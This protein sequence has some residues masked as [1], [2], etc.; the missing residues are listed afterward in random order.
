MGETDIVEIIR[1]A[2][3]GGQTALSE[4]EA[5]QF[6]A[7]LGIPVCRGVMAADVAAAVT[8][9]IKLG[10][11]VVLKAIGKDLFHKTEVRGI[12]LNLNGE[13][14]VRQEG[15]R[16]LGI[17]ESEALLV[18]EM[19]KGDRELVCGL[20]RDAQFGPCVMFGL[21]G[22]LTEVLQDVVFRVAP[23]TLWDAR[24][25][26]KEIQHGKILE[27]FRG[28]VAVDLDVLSR[29]LVT[30]GEIG[31][32]YQEVQSVDIN[33]LKIQPDGQPVA[34]DALVT[35]GAGKPTVLG[36]LKKTFRRNDLARFFEPESVAVIGASAMSGKA[37][38]VVVKNILAN[39]YAGKLY[40]VNP[41]GGE[42]LGMSVHSSIANLPDGVEQAIIMTPAKDTVQV[43]R[44][45]AVR[46]IKYVVLAAGG[47]SEVDK[48]GEE[49]QEELV[50]TITETGVRAIGPNTSGHI[51]T[52]HHYTSGFFPLDRI[53]QGNI[54]YVTQ[55]GNFAT[56]T[57]RY[58]TTGEYFGVARVI[59]LG[60]KIDIDESEV[61][62]YYAE[63]KET[64]AIFMYLE[65]IRRPRR[66][67][68][69]ADEVTRLKPVFL[70]KGGNTREG[71]RAAVTHT[72]ALA[73]DERIM[74]GALIQAGVTRLYDYSHLFLVAKALAV[75]PLPRGSGVSFLAPSGA[76]LVVLTDMCYQRWGLEVPDLEEGTRRRL[77]EISPPYIR[78]RNP[79]DIWPSVLVHDIEYSYRE[80]IEVLMRDIN[81]DA[82]VPVLMLTDDVG[83]P[84]LD[85]LVELAKKYPEKLLYVT[86]S[87]EKKHMEAAKSFLEP[88]GVPTFPLIEEPFEVISILNRCRQVMARPR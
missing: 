41:K 73:S 48:A 51:S 8:A 30:L 26:V 10:F 59:G 2:L 83:V 87:G 78:M 39:G 32:K 81:I 43:V 86:F 56:H 14:E 45:C 23:L 66:F 71:S 16:L 49:L 3:S 34:V 50:R 69:V 62:E 61:L 7:S 5:K 15:C 27:P 79:V 58:I 55:T 37:G 46:G 72:A 74:D 6:C 33:P 42:I 80:A 1:E 64:K 88:K 52:P 17:P 53:P 54:S 21:G 67:L 35:L 77:Q 12:A 65:D 63:D 18:Q 29:V 82:I 4:S 76:M 85:F 38:Y 70:L 9:A 47:F 31:V 22:V 25:M 11:P 36:E 19:V 40:L 24:E 28:E 13:E 20:V 44:D 57:M 68:E 84:P 60:N 75:M